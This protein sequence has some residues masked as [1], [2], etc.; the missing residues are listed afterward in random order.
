[1]TLEEQGEC[2]EATHDVLR[3]VGPVDA[4]DELFRTPGGEGRFALEDG[5]ILA[6]PFEL[7]HVDTDRMRDHPSR[8][9][10]VL[11]RSSRPVDACTQQPL[12]REQECLPPALGMETDHV[13]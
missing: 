5:R 13:V 1:M 6:E 9:A 12:D 11:D 3:G 7:A 10:L 8:A 4:K 2:L